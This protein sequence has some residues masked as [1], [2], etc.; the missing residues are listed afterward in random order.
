MTILTHAW[1]LEPDHEGQNMKRLF[2]LAVPLL[3]CSCGGSHRPASPP[4][5]Q[6]AHQEAPGEQSVAAATAAARSWLTL[7]DDGKYLESWNAAA[8]TFRG[9]VSEQTWEGAVAGARQPLGK[10]V[11][12][13]FQSGEFKRSLPGAPDGKYVV[14]RFSTVF[15]KKAHAVETVTPMQEPDGAWKIS[16]YF[17]R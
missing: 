16:G 5:V 11:S 13:E 4:S 12:R 3:V 7:V 14:V 8:A 6:P 10:V 2:S 17:I 9:A 1:Y 15:E